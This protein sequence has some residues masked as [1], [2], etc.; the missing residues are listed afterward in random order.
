MSTKAGTGTR[1]ALLEVAR[2]NLGQTE[3][4]PGSN[5]NPYA[6]VAGHLDGQPWC[7]TFLVACARRAGVKLESESAYTPHMA[8]GFRRAGRYGSR[9]AVGA[10]A[11]L[12]WPSLGRIAHVGVVEAVHADGSVTLIEGNTDARGGRTGGR[13]M[14]QRRRA[15]L[16]GYGY[17]R[18]T[19]P[20]AKRPELRVG[21]SGQAVRELQQ[22]LRRH[23]SRVTIDGEFGR[24]TANAVYAFQRRAKLAAD[25]VAGPET[26]KALLR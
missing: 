14:R 25:G 18:F 11:F 9:P 19:A 20:A 4:P 21:A 16:V 13:V 15:N 2:R 26:W 1:D 12:R 7:A 17:P 8:D 10:V 6:K 24:G 22:L 23:G 5:R 3:T